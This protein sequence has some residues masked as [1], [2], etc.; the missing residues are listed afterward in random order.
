MSQQFDVQGGM[1]HINTL[2]MAS[3]SAN[4]QERQQGKYTKVFLQIQLTFKLL[5]SFQHLTFCF[6]SAATLEIDNMRLDEASTQI[7]LSY[8]QHVG[9]PYTD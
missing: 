7:L 6:I 9:G 1:N 4:K 8:I 5:L 2:I 3:L